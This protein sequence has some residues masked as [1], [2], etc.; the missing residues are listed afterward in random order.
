MVDVAGGDPVVVAVGKDAHEKV[1][2]LHGAGAHLAVV[3][4]LGLDRADAADH[5]PNLH[6]NTSL[7]P[8]VTTLAVAQARPH[9]EH[10]DG[11]RL[12]AS[13]DI[14]TIKSS[15]LSLCQPTSR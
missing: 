9:L 10:W 4:Q 13:E 8:P 12:H 11:S 3:E 6:T 1:P 2:G 15:P 14:F 7:S 5:R